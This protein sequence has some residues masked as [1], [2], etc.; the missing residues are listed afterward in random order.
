M[1]LFKISE[2]L[3]PAIPA[4]RLQPVKN[5]RKII[6]KK[7]KN[8]ETKNLVEQRQLCNTKCFVVPNSETVLYKNS[9][10]VNT[11]VE[12]NQLEEHVVTAPS[13]EAFRSRLHKSK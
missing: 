5:K 7:F 11:L 6:A 13:L 2:G 3:V 4:E 9:F 12:W 1:F 10:F 8:C